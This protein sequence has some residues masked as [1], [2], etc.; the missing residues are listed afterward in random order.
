MNRRAL[1]CSA[2]MVLAIGVITAAAA[3]PPYLAA[4]KGHY[5]TAT[6]KP[7]LN[8][9]NCALC[10]IGAPPMKNFNPWGMAF[11]AGIGGKATNDPAMIK[12]GFD[13]A[14][15]AM[16]PATKETFGARITADAFPGGTSALGGGVTGTWVPLYNGVNM[17]GWTK[18]NAGTWSVQNLVL[19][20][21][22]NSGNGWLRC[23]LM[24]SLIK[25]SRR[26]C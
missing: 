2:S 4:F 18:M 21:A 23:W 11:L 16:N 6:G 14:A 13:T 5:A 26:G 15:K 7:T 8:G 20:Y 22:A 17:D 10:H 24:A 25:G 3:R 9:A 19:N 1:I 12:A